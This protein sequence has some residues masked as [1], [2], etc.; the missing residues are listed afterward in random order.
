MNRGHGDEIAM[1]SYYLGSIAGPPRSRLH[2]AFYLFTVSTIGIESGKEG[3][4][5]DRKIIF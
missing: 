4:E 5:E 2:L 3:G 1:A